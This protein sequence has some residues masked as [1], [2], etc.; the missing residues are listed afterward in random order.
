MKKIY[1]VLIIV[2]FLSSN[3]IYADGKEENISNENNKKIASLT[4]SDKELVDVVNKI[5]SRYKLTNLSVSSELVEQARLQ[6]THSKEVE[7]QFEPVKTNENTGMMIDKTSSVARKRNISF[8]YDGEKKEV[9]SQIIVI[10]PVSRVAVFPSVQIQL[11]NKKYRYIGVASYMDLRVIVLSEFEKVQD[12]EFVRSLNK[13][14]ERPV[15]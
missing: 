7:D 1:L 11:L 10:C 9:F 8:Y 13:T 3:F 2:C 12:L 15:L 14:K 6:I 5:R 4:K